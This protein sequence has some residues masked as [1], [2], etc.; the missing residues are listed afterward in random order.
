M[1]DCVADLE[2]WERTHLLD[3]KQ[4]AI[5]EIEDRLL[6]KPSK[7][8]SRIL[9]GLHAA[10]EVIDR[11]E[12]EQEERDRRWKEEWK[13]R[14]ALEEWKG[15]DA[16]Q[17]RLTEAINALRKLRGSNERRE[18]LRRSLQPLAER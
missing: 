16:E 2:E 13:W 17:R 12:S 11:C 3:D 4:R 15:Y 8:L 10:D 14:G 1:G 7:R 6:G 9:E 18:A 5:E